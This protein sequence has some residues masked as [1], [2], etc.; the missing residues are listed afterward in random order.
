MIATT[1]EILRA[2]IAQ[3]DNEIAE[4]EYLLNDLKNERN[5]LIFRL[6]KEGNKN[7]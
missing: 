3:K 6:Q 4:V 2:L 5:K 7:E 1:K